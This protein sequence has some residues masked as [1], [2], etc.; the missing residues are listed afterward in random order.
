MKQNP[1]LELESLGQ[2]IWIDFI[3]RKTIVSG[4]LKRLIEEDG[5]SGVTSNPSIF[6]KA[7]GESHDYDETIQELSLRGKPAEEIF[8]IL[9]VEDI[10][11]VAD[12]LHPTY[13]RKNGQD[14]FVS[15]EVS[16]KLAHDTIG[17][18]E[19]ARR[20]WSL[21]NRPNCMIKVPATR[22]GLPAIRQLIGEG[23]NINITLLF[24]LPRYREVTE[25]YLGGLETLVNQGR[26]LKQ[27]ASVASFF[28]SR[29]DTLLDPILEKLI[30]AGSPNGDIAARLHG[31]VAIASA[32]VAYQ[33]Y[34]E[35]F[36]S[37][38]F[39]KL[40]D[41]GARKQK[42]LWASTST[43]NPS[44]SDTKYIDP[45]IGLDTINT[46]PSE[47]L[48]IYKDHGRPGLTLEENLSEADQVLR[49]LS[50]IGIDIDE[51]TQELE[52]QGVEK[53]AKSL[54]GLMDS[55]REKQAAMLTSHV[56]K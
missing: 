44:Y 45:L 53:F 33:M 34:K 55:L 3:R 38:R 46:M 16:P 51:I 37:D 28:L 23:I 13:V 19:E 32:K 18:I 29:I 12:L 26:S 40:S 50:T 41:Q 49:D 2:S 52:D 42:L 48:V 21:V 7:I 8:Q 24:W 36:N 47:T 20:L 35:I 30:Q 43:K 1:L 10:Q 39:R 25:A 11:M 14:G 31:Q 54:N 56:Q 17:T 9:A 15:L 27:V 6:E 5:V 22:E 4:E